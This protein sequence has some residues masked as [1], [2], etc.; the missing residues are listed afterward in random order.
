MKRTESPVAGMIIGLI[1]P[2]VSLAILLPLITYGKG[3]ESIS[4]CVHQFQSFGILYK[5]VILS[6]MP[7]AVL[8]FWWMHRGR[9]NM[10]R[11]ILSMC[12][13]YGVAILV[14]YFM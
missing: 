14:M 12:L 11:G 8:F 5:I 10:A 13:L 6:L 1:L 4:S 9:V 3:Y 7:N 2:L